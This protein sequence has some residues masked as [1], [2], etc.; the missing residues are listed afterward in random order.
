ML[1]ITCLGSSA[2]ERLDSRILTVA[3]SRKTVV[4]T[5]LAVDGIGLVFRQLAITLLAYHEQG[6]TIRLQNCNVLD[7]AGGG[8][9][10]VGCCSRILWGFVPKKISHGG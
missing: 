10:F 1:V 4:E 2:Q 5:T 9:R 3:V 8:D 6:L 7:L